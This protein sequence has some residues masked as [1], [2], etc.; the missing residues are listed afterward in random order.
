MM[1]KE[2]K[3]VMDNINTGVLTL[4]EGKV[5]NYI[6]KDFD[7][8][9]IYFDSDTSVSDMKNFL[10]LTM[11]ETYELAR[12]LIDK[13]YVWTM[14]DDLNKNKLLNATLKTDRMHDEWNEEFE[15]WHYWGADP[16]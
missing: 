13:K 7:I 8:K 6:L 15:E 3:L 5:I 2:Q 4:L 16:V 12:N 9:H 10:N 11:D 14:G 1:Y